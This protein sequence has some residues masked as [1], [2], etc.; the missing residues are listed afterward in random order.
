MVE[1]VKRKCVLFLYKKER[2]TRAEWL[3]NMK[4]L[5]SYLTTYLSKNN[6]NA[7]LF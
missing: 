3:L 6:P 5:V 7:V 1:K 2:R 4:S